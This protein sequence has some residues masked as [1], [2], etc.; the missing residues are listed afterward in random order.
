[1]RNNVEIDYTGLLYANPSAWSG[2]AR[3][4]DIGATFDD[5]NDAPTEHEADLLAIASDWYAVGADLH[6]VIRRY[7]PRVRGLS[8]DGIKR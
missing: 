7:R 5:Y 4:L 2:A 6:R 1:M 3:V 8:A